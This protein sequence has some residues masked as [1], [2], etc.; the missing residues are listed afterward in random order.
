MIPPALWLIALPMGGAPVVYLLRR[1]GIGAVVAAAITA[2]SAWLAMQLPTGTGLDILGRTVFF[3]PL[4]QV[5]LF[6]LFAATAVLFLILTLLSFA[7]ERQAVYVG[8]HTGQEGRVFYPAAL[9]ILAIF[10][11]A[12]LSRH[13]GITA[14]FVELAAILMVF[15]IQTQRLESTRAAL[16]F[17]ILISLATPA[18]L[19]AAWYVDVY[20]LNSDLS[21]AEDASTI[22][23]LIGVG[24]AV[25]LAVVPFHGWLTSTAGESAPTTAAF[26]LITF[27]MI[28]FSILINLLI[29]LP[30]L[31]KSTYL[32]D[33]LILGGVV[34]AFVAGVLASVQRGFSELMGYAALFNI[35]CILTVLGLGSQA[36][37]VT[38]LVSL[39]VRALALIL[40]AASTSVIYFRLA[41]D[42]F[43]H[44]RGIAKQMPFATV[45]L[46]IGGATL[47]GAPFTAGFAP[48]WQLLSA[49]AEADPRW[50]ILF[51][52]GGLGVMTGY[53]RGLYATLL[54]SDS[55]AE[56][57]ARTLPNRQRIQEPL[58]LLILI[59][60]LGLSCIVL[61]FLPWLIIE[62]L[63][64]VSEQ[65][66]F[67]IR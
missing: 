53:L 67:V 21:L 32:I 12:T 50:V 39:A 3:D 55:V 36:A 31:I 17:L 46:L 22:A 51:V 42:G 26:V 1:V 11:A 59:V 34:T 57:R 64:Q 6:L 10:V 2:V 23:L 5:T 40:I 35:G 30:W 33:G 9:V 49:V 43:S 41:S 60:A 37:V 48:Y 58:P 15:V 54:P 4:S 16:R 25:W 8:K 65:I 28:A 52:V 66:P 18:F 44:V 56:S 13:L 62:P 61:G 20:Q 24:F 45:G 19:L 29:D 38:I 14:I 7:D 63:Q 47:A 27:P